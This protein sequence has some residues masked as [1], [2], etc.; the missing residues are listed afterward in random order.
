MRKENSM[1]KIVVLIFVLFFACASNHKKVE[2]EQNQQN[3]NYTIE[4]LSVIKKNSDDKS[5]F[6][7]LKGIL[8]NPAYSVKEIKISLEGDTIS[9]LPVI[10]HD[11]NKIVI[12]MA[13]PFEKEIKV[14]NIKR[15][16][17][18]GKCCN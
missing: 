3:L 12:Q 11:P 7:L 9:I 14:E 5:A 1:L 8:P 10:H 2:K 13:I 17:I 15:C 6:F 4:S 16:K 18:G